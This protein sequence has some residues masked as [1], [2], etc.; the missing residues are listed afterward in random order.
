[1]NTHPGPELA[2]GQCELTGTDQGQGMGFG[3]EESLGFSLCVIQELIRDQ[4][5]TGAAI[6]EPG[7]ALKQ[8]LF[9]PSMSL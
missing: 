1:M 7:G 3:A 6:S 9:P 5:H 8:I 4:K 2:D